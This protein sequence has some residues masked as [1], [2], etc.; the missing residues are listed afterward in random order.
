ME[1]DPILAG[2]RTLIITRNM[3]EASDLSEAVEDFGLG[4]VGV[5][6]ALPAE[7]AP[8]QESGSLLDGMPAGCEI[9]IFGLET[10]EDLARAFFSGLHARQIKLILIDGRGD[11]E[12]GHFSA[13][14]MRP[15]SSTDVEHAL[16]RLGYS[17]TGLGP[18]P[19]E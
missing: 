7:R 15:F 2:A 8:A 4:P 17:S 10:A 16:R 14:L 13:F 1:S 3:V 6:R 9:V 18:A 11:V 5:W 12:A 19:A